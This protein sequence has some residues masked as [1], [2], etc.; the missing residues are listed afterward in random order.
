[1]GFRVEHLGCSSGWVQVP[2]RPRS[3]NKMAWLDLWCSPSDLGGG[4]QGV[5]L[6][7][8]GVSDSDPLSL[9]SLL[10]RA[11]RRLG[12]VWGLGFDIRN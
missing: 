9:P 3:Y 7:G 6:G 10:P 4:I 5:L 8:F 12:L 2:P 11:P 1:M